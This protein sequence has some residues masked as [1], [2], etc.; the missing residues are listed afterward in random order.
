MKSYSKFGPSVSAAAGGTRG[1]CTAINIRAYGVLGRGALYLFYVCSFLQAFLE[2]IKLVIVG[3]LAGNSDRLAF[4]KVK[5]FK[6]YATALTS[7]ASGGSLVT[8]AA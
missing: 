6:L 7:S 8:L 1:S 5:A 4:L 3:G 2:T